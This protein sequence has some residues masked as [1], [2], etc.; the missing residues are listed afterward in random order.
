MNHP[1]PSLETIAGL[2]RA[3]FEQQ[4]AAHVAMERVVES[5]KR[6]GYTEAEVAEAA[7]VHAA[8]ATAELQPA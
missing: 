1:R 5:A 6:H 7:G 8:D 4:I 2:Y 3:A